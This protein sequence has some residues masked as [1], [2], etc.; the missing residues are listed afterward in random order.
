MQ[1]RRN[2][3]S[4]MMVVLGLLLVSPVRAVDIID[5]PTQIDE[6]AT[7]LIQ[8]SNSLCWEMHRF[9]QQQPGYRESYRSA[10][11][12]WSQ[13]GQLQEAIRSGPVETELLVGQITVMND[14]FTRVKTTLSQWESGDRSLI[15][16]G[17]EPVQR[18]VVTPGVAVEIPFIGLR[19]GG[20]PEVVVTTEGSS[21]IERKRLHP[22][23]RGSKRSLERELAAVE[24]ALNYLSE[25]AGMPVQ[26]TSATTGAPSETG[27]VP[28]A[29]TPDPKI[30]E[31]PKVV[32]AVE[33][34]PDAASTRK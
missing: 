31:T 23:S 14:L 9:H 15:A 2:Q 6:R 17:S 29:P 22:N 5:D 32:P 12:L 4:A 33:K 27:P 16:V 18:T 30:G 8:T 10:K 1:F 11:E 25:D 13:A 3:T 26:A 20:G 7:Q 34:K 28:L 21:Q 24:V 19:V